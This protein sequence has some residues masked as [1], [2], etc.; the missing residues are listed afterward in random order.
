MTDGQ[1][2]ETVGIEGKAFSVPSF[3]FGL[4]AV[5]L[6]YTFIAGWLWV[7]AGNT[8]ETLHAR[9]PSKT[10][11]VQ[12]PEVLTPDTTTQGEATKNAPGNTDLPV[13][14]AMLA[15]GLAEAPVEKLIEQTPLG[16]APVISQDGLT[17][18]KAYRRPFDLASAN[19]KPTVAIIITGLGLSGHATEAALRAMPADVTFAVSPYAPSPDLWVKESRARGHEVW[20][21]L[22]LETD[23]YPQSDPGP[24]T[25]MI[26]VPER[27]NEL[28]LSWLLTRVTGY[29]GFITGRHP[30]FMDS[31]N[32][33][34]PIVGAIYARGLGFADNAENGSAIPATIA[35]GMN[36]PYAAVDVWIDEPATP[37]GIRQALADLEEKAR[38]QGAAAGAIRALP[39]SYQEV[40]KWVGTLADK[41]LVL[42]P[43]SAQAGL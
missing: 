13:D 38:K 23:N 5:A 39:V 24:H 26:G 16:P 32:D 3:V 27:D 28:K 8:L 10:I 21:T 15:S 4:V 35:H 17:A 43:L 22:P 6:T 14:T 41:G 25:L 33:M 37:E 20:L 42:V 9:V 11:I 29:V 19:G 12:W 2:A 7:N 1:T 31:L 18:F 34:R 30:Q 36:A 40:Q